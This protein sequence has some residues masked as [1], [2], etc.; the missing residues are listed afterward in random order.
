MLDALD[1]QFSRYSFAPA[2]R[3]SFS[4]L[5]WSRI[6]ALMGIMILLVFYLISVD[7]FLSFQT[8]ALSFRAFIFRL[9]LPLCQYSVVHFTVAHSGAPRLGTTVRLLFDDAAQEF[10]LGFRDA[11]HHSLAIRHFSSRRP[12]AS[13]LRFDEEPFS[14]DDFDKDASFAF[15]DV[16]FLGRR[17]LSASWLLSRQAAA[18]SQYLIESFRWI[19]I[20]AYEMAVRCNS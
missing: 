10:P 12:L 20:L 5:P 17:A 2:S 14:F 19:I 15:M 8:R 1:F 6:L 7:A 16:I 11:F 3:F 18:S 4:R 9:L 13:R